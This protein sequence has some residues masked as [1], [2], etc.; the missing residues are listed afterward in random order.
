MRDHLIAP[1]GGALMDL[2]VEETRAADLKEAS[3]DWGSWD[4]TSRQLCDLELLLS[5]AFSPLTGVMTRADYD[6][7]CSRMRLA[8]GTLWPV[9]LRSTSRRNWQRPS[10]RELTSR[11]GMLKG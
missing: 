1:H 3:R 4:L 7:V 5:G 11:S 8:D 2:I 10:S 9:P 6:Q